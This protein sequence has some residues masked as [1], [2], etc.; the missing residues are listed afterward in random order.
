[1]RYLLE[2]AS[3]ASTWRGII[4]LLMSF[5]VMLS[6]EQIESIVVIG[7]AG[8]GLLGAFFPDKKNA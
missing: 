5:G 3:E 4:A 8:V 7:L 6:P 2:R 1:M